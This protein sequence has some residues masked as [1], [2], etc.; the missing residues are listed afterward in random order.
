[1][2]ENNQEKGLTKIHTG[3]IGIIRN[4]FQKLLF[5]KETTPIEAQ[6]NTSNNENN[7]K[8]NI[9]IKQEKEEKRILKLQQDFKQ[10]I[11]EEED[12]P[13]DDYTNLLKLYDEQNEKIRQEIEMYR[14][15]TAKIL[16]QLKKAN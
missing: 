6:I 15:E 9:Q 8:E 2:R 16:E 1:M 13:E 5:G 7:F 14:K 11:I 4:F 12:I 10:G 3:I